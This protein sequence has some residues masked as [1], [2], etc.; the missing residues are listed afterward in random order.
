MDVCDTVDPQA[1]ADVPR[2]VACHAV[3][4]NVKEPA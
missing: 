2:V 3:T 4:A 1:V